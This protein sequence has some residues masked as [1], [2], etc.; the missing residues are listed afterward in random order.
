MSPIPSL[1]VSV[2]LTV[3]SSHAPRLGGGLHPLT[4]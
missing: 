3:I 2:T 1:A 4:P